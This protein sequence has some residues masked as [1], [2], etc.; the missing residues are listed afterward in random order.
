MPLEEKTDCLVMDLP[1]F[2]GGMILGPVLFLAKS[3]TYSVRTKKTRG[4]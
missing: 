4:I 3:L 2:V 1:G